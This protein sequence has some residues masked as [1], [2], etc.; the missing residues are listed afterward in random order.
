M[1]I[2]KVTIGIKD[3][4]NRRGNFRIYVDT[5]PLSANE[6]ADLQIFVDDVVSELDK[7]INGAVTTISASLQLT[8]A[9]LLK[10]APL[11]NADIEERVRLLFAAFGT[12]RYKGE[13]PT[14]DHAIFPPG[15]D[16]F[17][18]DL[19]FFNLGNGLI[20]LLGEPSSRGHSVRVVNQYGEEIGRATLGLKIFRT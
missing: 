12:T 14:F 18:P 7:V 15:T 20:S 1:A 6:L 4:K 13:I 10:L 8:R 3:D 9:P 5:N 16:Q 17:N 2:F 19:I 11:V